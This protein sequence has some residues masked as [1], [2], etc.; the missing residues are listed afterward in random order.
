MKKNKTVERECNLVAWSLKDKSGRQRPPVCPACGGP[1][2]IAIFMT[3]DPAYFHVVKPS[4]PKKV[5]A[6]KNQD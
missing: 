3:G 1:A 6:L 2:E 5:K 4:L